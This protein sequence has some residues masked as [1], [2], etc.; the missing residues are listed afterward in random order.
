MCRAV[1]F[2]PL[3]LAQGSQSTGHR[4]A[5]QRLKYPSQSRAPVATLPSSNPFKDA[6][7]QGVPAAASAH[8]NVPAD[9]PALMIVCWRGTG[10]L[11][12][13]PQC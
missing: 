2:A 9:R 5:N 13:R 12:P 1:T 11:P 4:P 8:P 3:A 10:R 6:V 7:G